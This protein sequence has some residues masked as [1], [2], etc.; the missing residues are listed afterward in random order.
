MVEIDALGGTLPAPV[1]ADRCLNTFTVPDL[2][3]LQQWQVANVLGAGGGNPSYECGPVT[4]Y[5]FG[6]TV[7]GERVAGGLDC[8]DGTPLTVISQEPAAGTTW[9]IQQPAK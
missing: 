6:S 3:G 5:M 4:W 9:T 8:P 2:Y 1:P 7:D